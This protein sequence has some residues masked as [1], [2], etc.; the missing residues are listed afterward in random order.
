MDCAESDRRK[1]TVAATDS[2]LVWDFSEVRLKILRFCSGVSDALIEVSINPATT[3][4]ERMPLIPHSRDIF[5]ENASI[6]PFVEAYIESPLYPVWTLIDEIWTLLG[7]CGGTED[8]GWSVRVG[9]EE[10][11]MLRVRRF[12]ACRQ[13]PFDIKCVRPTVTL[14]WKFSSFAL[15]RKKGNFCSFEAI[16]RCGL[17]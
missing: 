1:S 13:L 17:S 11:A 16:N 8:A 14:S 7:R 12:A 5:F 9:I 10:V 3:A 2:T 4:F 15:W 6:A